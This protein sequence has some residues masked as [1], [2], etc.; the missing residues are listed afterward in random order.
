[1]NARRCSR[2]DAAA[3]TVAVTRSRRGVVTFL[4][5]RAGNLCW[6]NPIRKREEVGGRESPRNLKSPR[7]IQNSPKW[8]A[9]LLPSLL[10]MC[11]SAHF[12]TSRWPS[13]TNRPISLLF[14]KEEWTRMTM[15]KCRPQSR[16]LH[17]LHIARDPHHAPRHQSL[18]TLPQ[19]VREQHGH[20]HHR[21]VHGSE[22]PRAF[23]A[24]SALLDTEGRNTR[25]NHRKDQ[26]TSNRRSRNHSIWIKQ[27]RRTPSIPFLSV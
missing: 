23:V 27:A 13:K 14:S 18:S 26:D 24:I 10:L 9:A 20:V 4:S 2:L 12:C 22:F 5:S 16:S 6:R 25:S 19:L 1:M 21:S 8:M 7:H 17:R 3:A 15:T 11:G